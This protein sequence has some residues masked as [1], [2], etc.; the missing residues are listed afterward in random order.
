MTGFPDAL[1]L[2]ASVKRGERLVHRVLSICEVA[3]PL[4]GVDYASGQ[5]AWI[6]QHP[7]GRLFVSRERT[8]ALFFATDH[9]RSGQPRYRWEKQ[10]DGSE[11]GWLVEGAEH[12]Q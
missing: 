11:W 6:Q 1:M 8:A 2:A 7:H 4:L 10:A 12:A 5:R 3:E 9:P